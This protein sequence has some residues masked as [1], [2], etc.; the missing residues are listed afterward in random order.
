MCAMVASLGTSI[1]VVVA[2]GTTE[3]TVEKSKVHKHCM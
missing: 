3:L 2:A 1:L